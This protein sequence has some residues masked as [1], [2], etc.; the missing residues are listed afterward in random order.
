MT[1]RAERRSFWTWGY[2]SDEP[3]NAQRQ[4][5]AKRLA[6]RIGEALEPPPV[7]AI[8]DVFLPPPR[9]E[10]P[11]RLGEWVSTTAAERITHTYGGHSLELLKALRGEFDHPPDAV[12]HPRNEDELEATL[13]WCDRE[14]HAAIPYGGGTSVVWGVNVPPDA[15]AA[16]TIDL[17][18]LNAVLE[19]DEVSRAARIQAGMLGPDSGG[20]PQVLGASRSG[21]SRRASPGPP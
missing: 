3:S 13:A 18:N 5:A 4:D 10:V 8:G 2:V 15:N 20:R 14:G 11:E 7:P 9:L 17:D 1:A 19:V 12:A 6:D 21:T 16:V